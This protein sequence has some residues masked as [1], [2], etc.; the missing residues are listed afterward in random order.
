[1]GS[2]C[3]D[4]AKIPFLYSTTLNGS[5]KG[6]KRNHPSQE[7]RLARGGRKGSFADERVRLGMFS[8]AQKS[9]SFSP[10]AYRGLRCVAH[11]FE[12][13]AS[14]NPFLV[15]HLWSGEG[16]IMRRRIGSIEIG[17]PMMPSGKQI[18]CGS[19]CFDRIER[20]TIPMTEAPFNVAGCGRDRSYLNELV[21]SVA[22]SP[23][24]LCQ[25]AFTRQ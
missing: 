5:G 22:S 7:R 17:R 14:P 16:L 12:P 23:M 24:S 15:Q 9:A 19:R 11:C 21:V 13:R 20:D 3:L 1:M 6:G 25:K 4:P 10:S 2:P 18:V 8:S